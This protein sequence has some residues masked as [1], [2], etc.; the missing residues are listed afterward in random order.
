MNLETLAAFRGEVWARRVLRRLSLDGTARS[1]GPWPGKMAEAKK[2][3]GTLGRPRLVAA[4]AAII[5][6][7]A[8]VAWKKLSVRS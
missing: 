7:R 1:D 4:L 8:S 3:A 2:L 6:E 5:Q